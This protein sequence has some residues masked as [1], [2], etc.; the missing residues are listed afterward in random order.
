MH[1]AVLWKRNI[2]DISI[3]IDFFKDDTYVLIL[4]IAS[5][6][7]LSASVSVISMKKIVNNVRNSKNVRAEIKIIS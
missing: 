1:F 5:K 4:L 3:V 6:F 7:L 2:P